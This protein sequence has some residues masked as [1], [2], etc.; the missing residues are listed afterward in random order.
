MEQFRTLSMTLFYFI[1]YFMRYVICTFFYI[2]IVMACVLQ[3]NEYDDD[4]DDDDEE[5][6]VLL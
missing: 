5:V 1:F 4:D 6:I 2:S 3:I